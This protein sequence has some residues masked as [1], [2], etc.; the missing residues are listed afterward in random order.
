MGLFRFLFYKKKC[1]V[2]TA[3][4][5]EMYFRASNQLRN[6]DVS[7]DSVRKINA[8]VYGN[9]GLSDMPF[10]RNAVAANSQYDFYVAKED[11]HRAY[12]ALR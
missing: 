8:N 6:H 3:F 9:A 12:Q 7:F 1:L 4:G 5:N 11:E 2:H 10:V